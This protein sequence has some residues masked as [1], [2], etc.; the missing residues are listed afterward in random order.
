MKYWSFLVAKI[1]AVF[2]LLHVAWPTYE[3]LL[4]EPEPFLTAELH[5]MGHDLAYTMGVFIYWLLA[6]GLLALVVRDQRYRCRKCLR[7]LR[8]PIA[9]GIWGKTLLDRPKV[10]YI[11]PY[12]HGTLKVPELHLTG[13]EPLAWEQHQDMWT[14]LELIEAGK[15]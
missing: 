4:P 1:A 13:N 3:A 9:R 15:R 2:L 11:C 5:P 8:M 7:R 12:G 14:E 10:E 6:V